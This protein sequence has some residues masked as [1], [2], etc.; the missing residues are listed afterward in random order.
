MQ[1]WQMK[2]EVHV[3]RHNDEVEKPDARHLRHLGRDHREHPARPVFFELQLLRHAGFGHEYRQ[4]AGTDDL[5]CPAGENRRKGD[6]AHPLQ[7]GFLWLSADGCYRQPGSAAGG[8]SAG[9]RL[10]GLHGQ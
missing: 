4:H 8:F 2:L 6:N 10:Q 7:R 5:R 3:V 9:R 1:G